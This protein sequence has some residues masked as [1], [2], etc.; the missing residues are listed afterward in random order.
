[1]RKGRRQRMKYYDETRNDDYPQCLNAHITDRMLL[2]GSG[3]RD[4]TT[5]LS[6]PRSQ[7]SPT[8]YLATSGPNIQQIKSLTAQCCRRAELVNIWSRSHEPR[9]KQRRCRTYRTTSNCTAPPPLSAQLGCT[10]FCCCSAPHCQHRAQLSCTCF[11]CYSAP[12]CWVFG[13]K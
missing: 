12:S 13:L 11:R 7:K 6:P 2:R 4:I 3:H 9:A 10:R 8:T 5:S 1:M